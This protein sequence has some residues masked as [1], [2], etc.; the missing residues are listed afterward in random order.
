[1]PSEG[2]VIELQRLLDEA[3][4]G[5]SASAESGSIIEERFTSEQDRTTQSSD[6]QLTLDDAENPL[7]LLARATDLR[8]S[9]PQ[10]SEVDTS[11][12][13]SQ[14]FG[15]GQEDRSSTNHFFQPMKA[16]LDDEGAQNG[17]DTDPIEVG[18]VTMEEAEMLLSL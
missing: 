5:L 4:D 9:N 14:M 1:L 8:P 12:R 13:S 10:R 3:R 7:Q 11:T 16:C 6:E 15:N 18:L 2:S 17:Q